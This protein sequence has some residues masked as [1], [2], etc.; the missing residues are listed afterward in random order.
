MSVIRIPF[1]LVE[2]AIKEG[3]Q[4]SDLCVLASAIHLRPKFW[5]PVLLEEE[6][7]DQKKGIL[8][9][10]FYKK[11][12]LSLCVAHPKSDSSIFSLSSICIDLFGSF[13]LKRN[14]E[15]VEFHEFETRWICF[16]IFVLLWF[17]EFDVSLLPDVVHEKYVR[18]KSCAKYLMGFY[19]QVLVH[20][21]CQ[22]FPVPARTADNLF[23]SCQ[24]VRRQP[25]GR[26]ST[27][28]ENGSFLPPSLL[29]LQWLRNQV[30]PFPTVI[31]LNVSC[32][33]FVVGH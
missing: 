6:M 10:C 24:F 9:R 22:S 2:L 19:K 26:F 18:R 20:C 33:N 7:S 32:Q 23:W 8:F 15:A 27:Y 3:R 28:P 16:H 17:L 5:T 21:Y 14:P 1:N 25:I 30:M 31:S 11:K 13:M 29:L 12:S 4:L